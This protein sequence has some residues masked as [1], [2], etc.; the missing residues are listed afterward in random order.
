MHGTEE[1]ALKNKN[2]DCCKAHTIIIY[3]TYNYI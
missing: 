1:T 3:N 2:Y